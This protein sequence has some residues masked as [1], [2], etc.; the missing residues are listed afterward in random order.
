MLILSADDVRK[1]LPMA[2]AMDAMLRAFAALAHGDVLSP[3]RLHL[4]IAPHDGVSL[5]MP[6]YACDDEAESLAVK[7]VS[8]FSGNAARNLP[9]IQ[10]AVLALDPQTGRP[11]A[12]LEGG[13]LTAIRTAAASG[14]ATDLLAREKCTRVAIFGAGVQARAQLE[15][16]CTIRRIETVWVH[17]PSYDHVQA[18]IDDV[19][20]RWPI[21]ADVR[22]AATPAEA[23]AEADILCMAT[24]ATTPVLDDRHIRPGTHINAIGSFQPHVREL[25]ERTVTRALV[26][27]DSLAAAREEA[28]DLIQ[29]VEAGSITWDHV[30]AELGE[31]LLGRKRGRSNGEQ[32]TLFKSVGLAVQD[33]LAAR[34]AVERA[35]EMGLGTQV[36]W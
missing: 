2:A 6:A 19:A 18:M 21:P 28:G 27:V 35:R 15:A 30:H 13:A 34:V 22:A 25:S 31:L 8:L 32:I 3:R 1:A 7:V 12:L 23:A 17:A 29:A 26:V 9:R 4:D 11:V 20:G 24:T 16:V 14:V 33:A 36:K 10:S 5:I